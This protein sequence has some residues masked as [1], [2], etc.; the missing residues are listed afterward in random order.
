[1]ATIILPPR[2]NIVADTRKRHSY[3][4]IL[5]DFAR[6]ST[7]AEQALNIMDGLLTGENW[8]GFSQFDG[9]VGETGCQIRAAMLTEFFM[10][11]KHAAARSKSVSAV[12]RW[13]SEAKSEFA[14]IRGWSENACFQ[15]S[16]VG[17]DPRTLGL[18]LRQDSAQGIL[19]AVL[20]NTCTPDQST[21][22][23]ASTVC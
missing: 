18:G 19:K 21:A 13:L 15:L 2:N 9:H 12:P 14:S 6:S 10:H 5:A 4:A 1:M 3:C 20:R 8:E 7:E 16:Q 23:F 17:V 22:G 11:H